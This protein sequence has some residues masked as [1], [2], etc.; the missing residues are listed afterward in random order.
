MNT[1]VDVGSAA[2]VSRAAAGEPEAW[3]GLIERFSGMVFS[4]A[5]HHGLNATDAADVSQTVWLRLVEHLTRIE[6]PER[7]AGWLAVTTQRESRRFR[8]NARRNVLVEDEEGLEAPPSEA[9][10][11]SALLAQERD[12][13]VAAA[14]KQLSPRCQQML[15]MLFDEE[16]PNYKQLAVALDMPSGSIG[17]TRMR[18]LQCLRRLYESSGSPTEVKAGR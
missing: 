10:V 18:C 6:N 15:A 1:V 8:R 11:D 12:R 13:R 9:E 4:V 16:R 14:C 17:P 7:V 2:L 3:G 5:R